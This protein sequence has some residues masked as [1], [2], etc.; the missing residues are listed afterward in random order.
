[1]TGAGCCNAACVTLCGTM[2]AGA[3]APPANEVCTSG[4]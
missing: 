1:M 2:D 3:F 4:P